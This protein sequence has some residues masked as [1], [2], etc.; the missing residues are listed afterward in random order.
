MSFQFHYFALRKMHFLLHARALAAEGAP[1][2]IRIVG[3]D[4]MPR[5]L[6]DRLPPNP[7]MSAPMT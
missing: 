1:V 2:E 4:E 6:A 3:R 7:P 5:G